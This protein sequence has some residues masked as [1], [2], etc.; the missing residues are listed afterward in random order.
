MAVLRGDKHN[1]FARRRL[2]E[3]GR[4]G[5]VPVVPI[6]RNDLVMGLIISSFGVEN[7]DRTSIKIAAFA[8]AGR[9]VRAGIA[10]R[11]PFTGS[12]V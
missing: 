9:K 5:N 1:V 2:N 8:H 11:E 10:A 3:R 4:A 12:S 6:F 7:D